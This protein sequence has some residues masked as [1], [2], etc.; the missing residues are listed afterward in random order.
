MSVNDVLHL[1][2]ESTFSVAM[3]CHREVSNNNIIRLINIRFRST[4]DS[5]E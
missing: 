1:S 3:I 2:R 4:N 5:Q